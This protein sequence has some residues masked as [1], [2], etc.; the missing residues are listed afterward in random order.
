VVVRACEGW[1]TARHPPPPM[2]HRGVVPN[3]A[4]VGDRIHILL[5]NQIRMYIPKG[6]APPA[7][8]AHTFTNTRCNYSKGWRQARSN[9]AGE[10]KGQRP[11]L[12][13][14]HINQL[15]LTQTHGEHTHND[16]AH[17]ELDR[18]STYVRAFSIWDRKS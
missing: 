3:T 10:G 12:P 13:H 5:P 6:G 7:P 2:L 16:S 15:K 1:H 11:L 17:D 18:K 14:P 9:R 8:P 4:D